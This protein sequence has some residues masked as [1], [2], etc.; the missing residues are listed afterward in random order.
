MGHP[1]VVFRQ[2]A[3]VA[4]S[5]AATWSCAF[6]TSTHSAI[7]AEALAATA[8][9]SNPRSTPLMYSLGI[10][11]PELISRGPYVDLGSTVV[12][13]QKNSPQE[14]ILSNV[15]NQAGLSSFPQTYDIAGWVAQGAIR[16]DDNWAELRPMESDE[17]G[18]IF[19]RVFGH[20]FDPYANRGLV[21]GAGAVRSVDWAFSRRR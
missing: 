13:R 7:T 16:E 12:K 2:L 1:F 3:V 6:E 15:R 4:T 17:P 8:F 14:R 19:M 21:T 11:I 18:G 10:E 5:F 20:F 9:T